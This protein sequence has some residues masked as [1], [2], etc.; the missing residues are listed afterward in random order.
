M[1]KKLLYNPAELDKEV[2]RK[3]NNINWLITNKL[4]GNE[5][6]RILDI[7]KTHYYF[8]RIPVTYYRSKP[9]LPRNPCDLDRLIVYKEKFP[10]T[11]NGRKSL[12][13]NYKE[14][15]EECANYLSWKYTVINNF[16]YSDLIEKLRKKYI[17]SGLP[18]A[19]FY[20]TSELPSNVVSITMPNHIKLPIR[21]KKNIRTLIKY[22]K[23]HQEIFYVGD[24]C[25]N[26]VFKGY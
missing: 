19:Y 25:N 21:D 18:A 2:K 14:I 8:D 9:K 1:K 7:L 12:S 16:T 22:L 20:Q 24:Y 4:E 6:F 17:F 11:D 23:P 10:I 5:F 15:R 3:L 26:F 13:I